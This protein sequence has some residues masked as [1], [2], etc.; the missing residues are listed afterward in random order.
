MSVGSPNSSPISKDIKTKFEEALKD[1]TKKFIKI[2]GSQITLVD[3]KEQGSS[4]MK[5]SA[6]VKEHF[7]QSKD[8]D[9][10]QNISN[11]LENANNFRV[12]MD[13]WSPWVTTIMG[14]FYPDQV[15]KL[16][17]QKVIGQ[18]QSQL[19]TTKREIH[20]AIY[21]KLSDMDP[22]ISKGT[23]QVQ[24]THNNP[25][26][27]VTETNNYAWIKEEG[28]FYVIQKQFPY[29]MEQP[30]K[31][32][33]NKKTLEVTSETAQQKDRSSVFKPELPQRITKVDDFQ[34]IL[35]SMSINS[36]NLRHYDSK[37]E[38]RDAI[39]Q[40]LSDQDPDIQTGANPRQKLHRNPVDKSIETDYYAWIKEEGD[41]Y[42]I[43]KQFP[44]TDQPPLKVKI[45]KKTLEV[46]CQ[47]EVLSKVL[48]A[49]LSKEIVRADDFQMILNSMSID[50]SNLRYYR[51][52][53]KL[54]EIINKIFEIKTPN[55]NILNA[56]LTKEEALQWG[57]T[58]KVSF[59]RVQNQYYVI[60]FPPNGSPITTIIEHKN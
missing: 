7:G 5:V 45:N 57:F 59:L 18:I 32:K 28:D 35:N 15:D 58:D 19:E 55:E 40:K 8:L 17:P 16:D 37:H 4:L 60:T 22:V 1:P 21:Q 39:F 20:D 54:V 56:E 9:E 51:S 12:K 26:N 23:T 42:V 34:S 11:Y 3:Q 10:L 48:T 27:K 41:F 46:T 33:I 29:S 50:S 52:P 2:Q 13:W 47:N 49:I 14:F 36:S 24:D 53:A 44:S 30:L 6:F 31:V 43:Q 38:F 25:V